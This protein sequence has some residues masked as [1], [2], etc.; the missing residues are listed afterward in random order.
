LMAS[1]STS[2]AS[3]LEKKPKNTIGVSEGGRRPVET[4]RTAKSFLLRLGWSWRIREVLE[5]RLR[6]IRAHEARRPSVLHAKLISPSWYT[7][8]FRL[9]IDSPI[10][11]IVLSKLEKMGLWSHVKTHLVV[12]V[13]LK[14][15]VVIIRSYAYP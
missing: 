15:K 5:A 13:C 12:L 7:Y 3:V 14:W 2:S 6:R 4:M 10:Y 9:G 1:S 11:T 8:R